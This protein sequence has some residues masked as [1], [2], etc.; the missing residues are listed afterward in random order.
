MKSLRKVG[1]R[2]HFLSGFR[3][4]IIKQGI[5]GSAGKLSTR[6]TFVAAAVT[7]AVTMAL[8]GK[9]TREQLVALTD[10]GLP[11]HER[12]AGNLVVE[13]LPALPSF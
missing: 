7:T 10:A 1:A 11:T 3:K 9:G 4:I 12:A 2:Q 13:G 6:Q 5:N 8:T